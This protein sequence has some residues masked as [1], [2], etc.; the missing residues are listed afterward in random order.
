MKYS[1]GDYVYVKP[2]P[3]A[4]YPAVI[5][6]IEQ[7]KYKVKF[8]FKE[9]RKLMVAQ[10]LVSEVFVTPISWEVKL[11]SVSDSFIYTLFFLFF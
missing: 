1:I 8:F 4:T 3:N 7:G 5:E 2:F 11:Y 6:A 9:H 10:N